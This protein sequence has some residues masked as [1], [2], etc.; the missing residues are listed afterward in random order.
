[1]SSSRVSPVRSCRGGGRSWFWD[2]V[3]SPAARL[4]AVSWYAWSGSTRPGVHSSGAIH[5]E[6]A[7][8]DRKVRSS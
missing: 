2:M 6:T 8:I 4:G 1:M 5:P 7:G 3:L